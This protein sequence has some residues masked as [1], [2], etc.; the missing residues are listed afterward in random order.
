M[1]FG[2]FFQMRVGQYGKPFVIYKLKTIHPTT[3]R[4]SKMGLFFRTYKLDEFPQLLNVL[5]GDMSFVGPRPD[6]PGYYDKLKGEERKILQLKPGITSPASLKYFNE[7]KLL[8]QQSDPDRYNDCV[9][10]PDKVRMNLNYFNSNS[11]YGDL[12]II[13]NTLFNTNKS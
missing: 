12:K 7:E 8:Q 2:L 4:I 5:K 10:F 9:I 6:L 1:S 3:N 13:W 11:F